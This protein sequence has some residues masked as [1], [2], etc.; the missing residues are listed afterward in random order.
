M[1][2]RVTARLGAA[3]LLGL[4]GV[5]VGAAAVGGTA[6]P[7]NWRLPPGVAPP[8]VP[9]DN[10]MNA[11]KVM[12]GRR[13]F[14]DADL[15]VDGTM[16]CATCHEQKHGFAD[17]NRTHAG[18]HGDPGRRNVPGLA[19]VGWLR[20]LTADD[21]RITTLEA[22]IAVPL[23]GD[24]PVEMGMKGQEAELARRLGRDACY[25][26]LFAAAF[27]EER[28]AI[29]LPTVRRAVAT[30][31]RTLIARDSPYD[32]FRAGVRDAMPAQ[33]RAGL[34]S[35]R[36][37]CAACHAGVDL[38]DQLY[39]AL[40]PADAADTG[41]AETSGKTADA[42]RFRTPGLRNL[43]LTAPYLHDGSAA[44]IG[45]AIDRHGAVARRLTV[46]ERAGIE[47]FL[48]ELT[49][50]GFVTDPRFGYPDRPCGDG[51]VGSPMSSAVAR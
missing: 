5:V 4:V 47:A 1:N 49:D 38:T 11:A 17:G 22:Q 6:G 10:P 42:G 31:Q 15:S 39:H 21:P 37:H 23:F 12:L 19:N 24:H 33:A 2:R 29:G 44:T 41:L 9:A 20:R 7:W 16:S 46:A 40:G 27:P 14:Y 30:F 43:S 3:L 36:R 25:V 28:G 50:P 51:T 48:G 32:R 18:V 34:S 45:A 8:P 13:L 35:F 26:R